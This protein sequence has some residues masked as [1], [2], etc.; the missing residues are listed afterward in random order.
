M[1][2]KSMSR[3]QASFSQLVDYMEDG[4]QD[5]KFTLKNNLFSNNSEKIKG[6][7]ELNS[8]FFRKRKNSVYMYHEVISV[9]KSKS[10]EDEDQKE[11]LRKIVLEYIDKR[12]K[13]NLVYGVLHDDK[14]D[15]FHYHLLISSNELEETK[16]HRLSK[17]QF[18][19]IKKD[20]EIMVLEKYPELQQGVIINKPSTE[21]LSNK[22]AEV[23]RRTGKTSQRD[24]VKNRLKTVFGKSK[25]KQSFFENIEKE[26]LEIYVRGNTIGVVDKNTGRNHRL[27]TLGMLDDFN[28]ISN[29]VEKSETVNQEKESRQEELKENRKPYKEKVTI[30]RNY[31]SVESEESEKSKKEKQQENKESSLSKEEIEIKKRKEELSNSRNS[32]QYKEYSKTKNR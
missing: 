19:K 20:L 27:K 18:D 5:K 22:G 6:E 32:S 26:N 8:S 1:I 15:N 4:R 13:Y 14:K 21:K 2:I 30:K 28:K 9:T 23:K 16:Q 25:D 10:L 29:I 17:S 12:A 7:F 24:S 31:S 3:K 11:I